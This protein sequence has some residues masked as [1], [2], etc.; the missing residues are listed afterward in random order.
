M[1][2]VNDQNLEIKQLA[3]SILKI[4]QGYTK[5]TMS[6]EFGTGFYSQGCLAFPPVPQS[7][8]FPQLNQVFTHGGSGRGNI[9]RRGVVDSG[10]SHGT[11]R[12]KAACV[13]EGSGC[14]VGVICMY[15]SIWGSCC[16]REGAW[17]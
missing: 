17:S 13:R 9:R 16:M 12:W 7:F 8:A 6:T 14:F 1:I 11:D 5:T 10:V 3:K 2:R 15:V 4:Y